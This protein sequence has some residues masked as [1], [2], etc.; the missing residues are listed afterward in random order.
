[1]PLRPRSLPALRGL[2]CRHAR[3]FG[4]S[5]SAA[6]APAM[7][8]IPMPYIEET[9]VSHRHGL[10]LP[11]LEHVLTWKR[12]LAE[13]HVRIHERRSGSFATTDCCKGTSSPSYCRYGVATARQPTPRLLTCPGTNSLP[14]WRDQRLHVRIHRCAAPLARVRHPRE[15]NHDVYQFAGRLRHVRLVASA[16]R[17]PWRSS[18]IMQAWPFTI[19]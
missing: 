17:I 9:S 1:M 2:T 19:Q 8:Y 4:F 15:T 3:S 14:E 11:R 13:R 12:L 5:S 18:Q 6:A 7:D 16:H 10:D